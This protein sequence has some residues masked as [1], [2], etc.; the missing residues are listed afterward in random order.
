MD[1]SKLSRSDLLDFLSQFRVRL[2]P[3]S[4]PIEQAQQLFVQLQ[5]RPDVIFPIPVVDLYLASVYEGP[6]D[7]IYTP[8]QILNL[9]S[10][11]IE[12]FDQFFQFEASLN[13]VETN[14]RRILRIL[15]YLGLIESPEQILLQPDV[16]ERLCQQLPLDL[17][18]L[19]LAF[20]LIE[21]PCVISV[22]DRDRYVSNLYPLNE[23]TLNLVQRIT[24]YGSKIILLS[25][26]LKGQLE[27][28]RLLLDRG[29][30]PNLKNTSGK[31]ALL[32]A[33]EK[34]QL[35]AVRLLLNG[36]ADPNLQDIYGKTA[37]IWASEKGH[38]EV[39][40]LL[41]DREAD[42]DLRDMNRMTALMLAAKNGRLEVVRLLLERG[43]DP[44]LRDRN[45]RTVL[46][47]A[48]RNDHTKVVRLL[49]Q[50]ESP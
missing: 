50:D 21:L 29:V 18:N 19:R 23:Q 17:N 6:R 48:S 10:D 37:L 44:N 40:R 13:D 33:S 38:L 26:S 32:S 15:R 2:N 4:S 3:I 41:L 28:V 9:S 47:L 45:R 39:V 22:V 46:M 7:L 20:D 14:R 31:T 34:G 49:Q 16:L 35:E 24:Q 43:A 30:D 11:E 27:V 8:D 12:A 25:A 36:G 5:K 1:F 42:P